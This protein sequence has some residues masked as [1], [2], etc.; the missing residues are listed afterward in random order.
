MAFHYDLIV[1][2]SGPG[3]YVAAIRA[4]Q[5][6]MKTAI[7]EREALGGVCLNWGCIPTKA[8]LRTAEVYRL[9]TRAS[10]FGLSAENV[11]ID[12][13]AIVKRSRDVAA[14]LSQGVQFLMKKNKI[15]VYFG[16]GRL[17]PGEGA[18]RVTVVSE[19]G[20][21]S[22]LDAKHVILATG[23]RA[24][25]FPNLKADGKRIWTYREAMTPPEWP[26]TLLVFGAGAIGVEF[27]SF[28]AT[29][30]VNVTLIEMAERILP[31]EDEEA[32]AFA[33]RQFKKHG[34]DIRTGTRATALTASGDGVTAEIVT[35]GRNDVLKATHAILALGI[36][37]NVEGLESVG[38]ETANTHVKIDPLGRTN[39][40]GLYAIG[41][42]CGPPWLAHK[43]MHEGVLCVEAIAGHKVRPLEPRLVPSCTYSHPQIASIGMT[44][45]AAKAAGRP[46][47]AGKFPFSANGKA[48]ALGET[49]GFVKT[50]FDADTG[51]L[52]GAHM[53]GAEVTELIQ[54]YVTAMNAEAT[55]AELIETI[56][57]H[58]TLSEMMHEAVLAAYGRALHV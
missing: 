58:P 21:E 43:A 9:M 25:E 7:V 39:V 22:P 19:K 35:N 24:R 55:E 4:A 44:E 51:E 46:I 48:I 20:G 49:D 53:V 10:E 45:A 42:V 34:I 5:L 6:G 23:A 17:D 32:S 1:V 26:G 2:G 13:A 16:E 15:D 50:I 28:Y 57:P 38:V 29:L 3:G 8:L 40:A 18:P 52:L 33:A 30:G 31:V 12:P 27:A 11:T 56:F 37:G 47:K 14:K 41:D 36:V 54:G